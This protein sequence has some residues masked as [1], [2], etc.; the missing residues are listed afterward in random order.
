METSR[1]LVIRSF[2]LSKLHRCNTVIL[3]I[4]L[5]K[6]FTLAHRE[7]NKNSWTK[8]IER[9]YQKRDDNIVE[10]LCQSE[11][12]SYRDVQR[13]KSQESA[14]PV[15]SYGA[16]RHV[17]FL[18]QGP[19][20]L[21]ALWPLFNVRLPIR[22][23]HCARATRQISISGTRARFRVTRLWLFKRSPIEPGRR[24]T[25]RSLGTPAAKENP[26]V[27]FQLSA[28]SIFLPGLNY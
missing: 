13:Q 21:A 6:I 27:K 9:T 4:M 16:P 23:L 11:R 15:D 22:R 5:F 1:S 3:T 17:R 24:C 8:R 26:H 10:N 28:V 20:F 19:H 12:G 14:F 18:K 25:R 7:R 2:F